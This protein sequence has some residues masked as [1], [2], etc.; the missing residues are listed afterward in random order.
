M[1][2][3]LHK[4]GTSSNDPAPECAYWAIAK[5]E[6]P[7][8]RY[9]VLLQVLGATWQKENKKIKKVHL[10]GCC[11]I[12][13]SEE[14]TLVLQTDLYLYNLIIFRHRNYF[15]TI[16]LFLS[17]NLF[18]M[19]KSFIDYISPIIGMEN[20]YRKVVINDYWHAIIHYH[21]SINFNLL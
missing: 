10:S 3:Q 9:R 7:L 16:F 17:F 4:I 8:K 6:A 13:Y 14:Y 11:Q 5:R 1:R 18:V 12:N 21:N 20:K 19:T 2:T 15:K